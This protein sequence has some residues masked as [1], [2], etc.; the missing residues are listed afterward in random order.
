MNKTLIFSDDSTGN[1]LFQASLPEHY[2][3]RGR[4][5]STMNDGIVSIQTAG[6]ALDQRKGTQIYFESG[7]AYAASDLGQGSGVTIHPLCSAADQLNELTSDYLGQNVVPLQQ[8]GLPQE[9][10]ER[11]QQSGQKQ[12][13]KNLQVMSQVGNMGQI[14][15]QVQCTGMILDGAMGVYSYQK[16]YAKMTLYSAIARIGLSYTV[17]VGGGMFGYMGQNSNTT[18]TVPY[19]FTMTAAGEPNQDDLNIFNEFIKTIDAVP[20]MKQYLEQTEDSNYN[21]M[22]N[23]AAI[24]AQQTQS[25]IDQSWAQHEASWARVEAQRQSLSQDLDN[26]RAGLAANSASMDAFRSS[27]HSA[28]QPGFGSSESLDDKVQRWRHESMMGVNTYEREDGTT[29]EHTIQDDRVF[30]HQFDQNRHFGTQN[31][32]GDQIP[33]NWY[34]MNRKK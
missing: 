9:Y 10:Q 14:K 21:T 20:Q 23:Q 8:G 15:S 2:I 4:L 3:T 5:Y 31:Y 24:M 16:E 27:M 6:F 18:W 12:I 30:E 22:L 1:P 11:L 28:N 29:Y 34:E 33:D 7:K 25:M 32:F 26:F 17:V 13:Q 19:L